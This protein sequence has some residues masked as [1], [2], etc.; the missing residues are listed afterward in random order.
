[1]ALTGVGVSDGVHLPEE[2]VGVRW[3]WVKGFRVTEAFGG[4]GFGRV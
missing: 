4:Q 1:M 3:I 2:L